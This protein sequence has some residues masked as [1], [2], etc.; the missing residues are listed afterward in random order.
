[1]RRRRAT[2]RAGLAN[3]VAVCAFTV[4]SP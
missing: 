1:L 4:D 2:P 3:R